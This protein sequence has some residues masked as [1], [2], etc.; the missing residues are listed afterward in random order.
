MEN[1][2]TEYRL[3]R[4]RKIPASREWRKKRSSGKTWRSRKVTRQELGPDRFPLTLL[5]PPSDDLISRKISLDSGGVENRASRDVSESQRIAM[6]GR[7]RGWPGT[8]VRGRSS[9]PI[10]RNFPSVSRASS[11]EMKSRMQQRRLSREVSRW[12]G[13]REGG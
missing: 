5:D 3:I 10:L 2:N 7:R 8:L 13:S 6:D 1:R 11:L 4:R 9:H 12:R